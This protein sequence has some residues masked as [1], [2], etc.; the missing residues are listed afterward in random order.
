M[1]SIVK[2][3]CTLAQVYVAV[4]AVILAAILVLLF[5]PYGPLS[6]AVVAGL[7][8]LVYFVGSAIVDGLDRVK[9]KLG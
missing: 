3:A 6:W 5:L 2:F 7:V 9:E 1:E 8:Y 4:Q